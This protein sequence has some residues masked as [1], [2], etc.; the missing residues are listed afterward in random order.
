MASGD[1]PNFDNYYCVMLKGTNTC[2]MKI[3]ARKAAT[4]TRLYA[5]QSVPYPDRADYGTSNAVTI[6][7]K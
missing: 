7:A 4:G 3:T 5:D 6:S 2:T 1:D